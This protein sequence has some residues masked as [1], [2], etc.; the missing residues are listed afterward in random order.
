MVRYPKGHRYEIKLPMLPATGLHLLL[1]GEDAPTVAGREAKPHDI[2]V[3]TARSPLAHRRAVERLGI[4]LK[5]EEHYDF[6]IYD[7]EEAAQYSGRAGD[8]A[9]LWTSYRA[10]DWGKSGELHPAVG[11]CCFR[12]RQ[13]S[14]APAGWALAWAWF[15]PYERRRG[16]L[17]RAWPYFCER[18]GNFLPEPPL[19]P[20]MKSFVRTMQDRAVKAQGD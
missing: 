13:W 8:V 10:A 6:P 4:Y 12:W 3:V 19:T 5:R 11:A 17:K 18:F 1:P 20:A 2:T 9:F 16:H 15:H 14:D 7:A